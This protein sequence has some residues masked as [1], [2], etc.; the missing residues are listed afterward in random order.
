[1]PPTVHKVLTEG[2]F[3]VAVHD[4][5]GPKHSSLLFLPANGFHG[6]C[7]EPMVRASLHCTSPQG[8]LRKEWSP[9]SRSVLS[10][11]C[12]N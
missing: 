3:E 7:Y 1:M 6:L 10:T 8:L 9:S 2:G 11:L 12:L 4:F 5:G